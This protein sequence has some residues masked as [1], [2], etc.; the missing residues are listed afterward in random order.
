MRFRQVRFRATLS[1]LLVS[2]LLLVDIGR[3]NA[4]LRF[5]VV[6]VESGELDGDVE[7]GIRVFEGIP[8]A[9]PPVGELRWRAPRPAAPWS[10]LRQAKEFGPACPQRPSKHIA[11]VEMSEDCLTL[12]VWSPSQ[13]SGDRLPVM[14]WVHGGSFETGSA[15]MPIYNGANLSKKGVVVVTLNY[16]LGFFG[17]FGHPALT[18]EAK[19][20][21]A[22]TANF[23][24]L[25]QIAALQWVQR[26]IQAFG[27][28]PENVTLFGESAGAISAL[29]LMT[30]Q[31]ARG[32]FQ[33]AI[34][35]SGGG[36][37]VAPTLTDD[38]GKFLS[39]H[40]IGEKAARAF[41]LSQEDALSGLRAIDWRILGKTLAQIHEID[42]HSPFIDGWLLKDQ[43]E[44]VFSRGDQMRIPM[45][46][47]A[48]SYEGVLLRTL[49][50]V[51]VDDVLHAVAPHLD[52]LSDLYPPQLLMTPDFLADHIWGDAA[53]VEPARM[54]ARDMARVGEPVYH[55]CFDFQPPLLRLL[56]GTPHGLDVV[57]SFGNLRRVVPFPLSELMH[58][59][60]E[61]VSRVM[62]AFWTNFAKTGDPNGRT[63][64]DWP[65]FA[66]GD[67]ET[68]AF[69]NYGMSVERDYLKDRLDLFRGVLW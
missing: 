65:R 12:N 2:M 33:K 37:W 27:G 18:E 11:P 26:N 60:N 8:Y 16:R 69:G 63:V 24:L 13:R 51:S 10:G 40:E 50:H 32:L 31:A 43:M 61:E 58:P 34:I 15:R 44:A 1:M 29:S 55:Y 3:V 48:N 49:F 14:V 54:I 30:S 39:A 5:H 52:D 64:P 42:R 66:E 28:D 25:D 35:Q 21:N 47:G 62:V 56:G 20:E 41:G 68:L 67:E 45:I 9:A 7:D 19:A 57:Y 38:A 17:F 6:T 4:E 53:F 22:P 36:R 59:H 23:G 46:V